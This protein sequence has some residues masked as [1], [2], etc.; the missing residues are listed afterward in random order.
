[1]KVQTVLAWHMLPCLF[2]LCFVLSALL[3]SYCC[4]SLTLKMLLDTV[5]TIILAGTFTWKKKRK[6]SSPLIW[7]LPGP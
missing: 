4:P 2:L 3:W 7:E 1:M 6:S 5:V